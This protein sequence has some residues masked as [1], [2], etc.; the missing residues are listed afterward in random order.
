M[1]TCLVHFGGWPA[2]GFPIVC[3][4]NCEE[5]LTQEIKNIQTVKGDNDE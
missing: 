5:R 1:V 3:G 4:G 2:N